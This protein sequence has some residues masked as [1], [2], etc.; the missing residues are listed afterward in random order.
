MHSLY[1]DFLIEIEILQ[2][3]FFDCPQNDFTGLFL[4]HNSTKNHAL[5]LIAMSLLSL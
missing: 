4:V 1:L 2:H 3:Q 5:H